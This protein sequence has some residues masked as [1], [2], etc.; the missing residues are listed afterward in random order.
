MSPKYFSASNEKEVVAGL[1]F[2]HPVCVAATAFHFRIRCH[3]K[4]LLKKN[5]LTFVAGILLHDRE[6]RIP[7]SKGGR[8]VGE[9]NNGNR[10]NT[11]G[12]G[13]ECV[14]EIF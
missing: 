4:T 10:M 13:S 6:F 2:V 14:C 12:G 9:S 7:N 11:I 1:P 5:L 3:I 8:G